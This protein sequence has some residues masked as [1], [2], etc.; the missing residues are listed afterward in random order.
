MGES[1]PMFK[2][3]QRVHSI[4]DTRRIG[5]VKYVGAVQGY[6]GDWVGVDWD[7]GDGKNDGSI[8]G[9]RYFQAKLEKSASFVRPHLLSTGITLLEA[10]MIRYRGETTKE[11]EDEMYVLSASNK[12]VSIELVGK[13]KIQNKL[14]QFEE[15]CGASL[16]YLGV[17]SAGPPSQ[18]S[19][20]VPNLKEL[21]LTG[22][23]LSD[24]KDIAAVCQEL[25]LLSA[26]NLSNNMMSQ[27]VT[28]LP[29]LRNIR[30]L[31]LNYSGIKWTQVELLKE[32]LP[33]IEELHLMGNKIS[34]IKPTSAT[35]QSFG[36]LRILNLEENC[37]SEWGE[38]LKLS[39]LTSLEQLHLSKNN[40]SKVFYPFTNS[41]D[42]STH[43]EAFQNLRCLLLGANCISDL[44][45]VDSINSFPSLTDVRLSENPI[46]DPGRGGIPRF[47]LIARL[48]KV[49]VLNGSEVSYRERKE[50]EI[51]YVRLVMSKL[52][53]NQEEIKRSHPRFH[54]L[55]RLHGLEDERPSNGA[56]GPQKMSS[57]LLTITL[58]CVGASMGEKPLLTKKLPATT[59]VGKLKILCETFFKLKSIKLKLFLQEEGSPLPI[60]LDNEM[61]S[62]LDVGVGNESIIL[63]D[64]DA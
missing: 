32:F 44:D 23:L 49:E 20:I 46:A 18:V 3:E 33:S 36:S 1:K 58:K 2:I 48:A 24:W 8:N 39:E 43:I 19:S 63:V 10:L 7:N 64:E 29:M 57:G 50:S 14:S 16:A 26:L 35:A 59:T 15:L 55:K 38:V 6:S 56:K 42:K 51:R 62:L 13:D 30:V 11:E 9:V 21:D 45:S 60:L 61:D 53:D 37:I 28:C 52:H 22:N 41:M 4:G 25:P 54:E 34:E 17:S 31:V 12:K 27:D 47:A 40:I 5:T